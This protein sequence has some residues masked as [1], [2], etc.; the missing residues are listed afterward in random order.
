M[1]MGAEVVVDAMMLVGMGVGV[2]AREKVGMGA[3][4]AKMDCE[5]GCDAA[6]A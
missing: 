6:G 1:L 5:A 4:G 2:G 3:A